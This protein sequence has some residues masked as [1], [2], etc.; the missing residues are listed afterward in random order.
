M[1]ELFDLHVDSG[2]NFLNYP[3]FGQMSVTGKARQSGQRK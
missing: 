1:C 2:G 3:D